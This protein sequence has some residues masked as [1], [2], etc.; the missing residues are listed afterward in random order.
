MP[1]NTPAPASRP[2]GTQSLAVHNFA[3]VAP[4]GIA[5][6]STVS[7]A[8]LGRQSETPLPGGASALFRSR[9]TLATIALDPRIGALSATS[10]RGPWVCGGRNGAGPSPGK[11]NHMYKQI[12]FLDGPNDPISTGAVACYSLR[13][14]EFFRR[15]YQLAC[16]M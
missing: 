10:S 3:A 8:G 14:V 5:P 16:I 4:A 15:K 12:F 13:L 9:T 7:T 11:S 1:D 2:A 6:A